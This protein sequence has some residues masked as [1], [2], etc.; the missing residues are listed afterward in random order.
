[1]AI[2]RR[3]FLATVG[4]AA[5]LAVVPGAVAAASAKGMP[6]YKQADAPVNARVDDLIKRMTVDEKI[7]QLQCVWLTKKDLQ[8]EDTC[9]SAESSVTRL[10]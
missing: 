9:F 6:V 5:G 1:M 7:A 8:N 4:G 3:E 10:R 2:K